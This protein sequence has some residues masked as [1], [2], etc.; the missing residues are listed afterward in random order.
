MT[1]YIF[2]FSK[3]DIFD[4]NIVHQMQFDNLPTKEISNVDLITDKLVNLFKLFFKKKTK[5]E[6]G[7]VLFYGASSNNQKAFEPI[8][9]YMPNHSYNN[10]KDDNDYPLVK[11]IYL[12]LPYTLSLYKE[13]K[14]GTSYQKKLIKSNP[15]KYLFTYGKMKIAFEIFKD[16]KPNLLVLA[17][18]HSALNRCLLIASQFHEIK[19]LYVQHAAVSNKFPK[20]N[21][22]YAMLDGQESYEKYGETSRIGSKVLLT[23]A[24]RYDPFY[25]IKITSEKIGIS[26]NQFDDFEIV[27]ELCLKLHENGVSHL[28]IRPHPNMKDWNKDWFL[29]NNIEYSESGIESANA[30]LAT[31]KLQISNVCGIHLD[32]V[33]L[34]IPTVQYKLSY[35]DIEDIYKFSGS[36]LIRNIDTVEALVSY[37]LAEKFCIPN[38]KIVQYFMA[39]AFTNRQGKV[40][41]FTA[42]YVTAILTGHKEEESLEINNNIMV[43]KIF[44]N[45][46][47]SVNC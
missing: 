33:I 47:N 1:K 22:D 32:A 46:I 3:I 26:I 4:I 36:G 13:Y 29:N 28:V 8:F 39:S 9:K 40:G 2:N 25:G 20:L 7:K 41:K 17:N 42:E 18:D 35:N 6:G 16:Y 15:L 34:G 12:S 44:K 27:K 10:I 19:S 31:L 11:S 14:K 30:Y 38:E 24:T 21:F 23:G 43:Y 5:I 37:I 45:E